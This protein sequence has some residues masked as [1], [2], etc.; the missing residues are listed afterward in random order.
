[1]WSMRL[2]GVLAA[3]LL[4]AF[5][6]VTTSVAH[7]QPRFHDQAK[8]REGSHYLVGRVKPDGADRWVYYQ[9]R[10]CATCQWKPYAKVRTSE[11]GHFRVEIDFP[12]RS[13]PTWRYRGYIPASADHLRAQGRTWVA[14]ARQ[15][16]TN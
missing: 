6:S 13:K 3:S 1:M 7:E 8:V 10:L 4:L 11:T 15:T 12:R 9:R 2:V 5:F 16:C 14:C